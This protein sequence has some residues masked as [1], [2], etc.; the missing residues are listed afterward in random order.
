MQFTNCRFLARLLA[1]KD[2]IE[3]WTGLQ[4][5]VTVAG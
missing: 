1:Y 4:V 5:D 2:G 3:T